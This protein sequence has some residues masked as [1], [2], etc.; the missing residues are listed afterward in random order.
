[1]KK[2][3]VMRFSPCIIQT[4]NL[5][6]RSTDQSAMVNRA[7][8][9]AWIFSDVSTRD[10]L[11]S[12]QIDHLTKRESLVFRSTRFIVLRIDLFEELD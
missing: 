2:H 1:M 11:K 10:A 7:L 12:D 3:Y 4:I 6:P 5:K 8:F 9:L